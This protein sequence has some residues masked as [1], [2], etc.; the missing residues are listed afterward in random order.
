[1]MY[2][3]IDEGIRV[4]VKQCQH[5]LLGGYT[6]R[7]YLVSNTPQRLLGLYRAKGIT[8]YSSCWLLFVTGIDRITQIIG[9]NSIGRRRLFF[10]Q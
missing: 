2:I 10:W 8:R 6:C 5:H 1:M 9:T 3:T 4:G 7:A